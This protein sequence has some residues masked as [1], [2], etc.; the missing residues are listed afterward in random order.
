MKH[1]LD[2]FDCVFLSYDE[3]NAEIL[4]AQLLNYIPWAKR[5][6]GV[7]GF[8]T[9]HIACAD[10]SD[11][12]FF[13]TVD[14]DNELYPEFLNLEIDID[15]NQHDHA[16]TWS[17]RNN[18][19]GL[20]YGNGGLK[21][22][23]KSFVKNMRS[24]ENADDPSKSVEFCWDQKYHDVKG[25]YSTSHSNGS[26]QQAWRSGFREGVKM[27]LDRGMRVK[28]T[29]FYQRVWYGNINRLCIWSSIGQDVEN[30]IWAIYGTRM[31]A[32][33]ALLTDLDHSVISYYDTMQEMWEKTCNNDPLSGAIDIGKELIQKVGLDIALLSADESRFFKRVYMNPPRPWMP[34][35][36]IQHF[37]ALRHV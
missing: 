21:L 31:G 28:P 6:H 5:V 29:E 33:L 4:Y 36:D 8:D 3:P 13:I 37:M 11:T 7:K 1:R 35:L 34:D 12:H 22:W 14:G 23:S 15:E 32:Y 16:W 20:V 24:H 30:G 18:I 19:N 26:P 17:S 25:C 9:A 2:S 27:C 10:A